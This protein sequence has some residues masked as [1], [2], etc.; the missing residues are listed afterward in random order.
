[1][2][3]SL[4][5]KKQIGGMLFYDKGCGTPKC[6]QNSLTFEKF[7]IHFACHYATDVVGYFFFSLMG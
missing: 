6:H 7:V 2:S 1:M 3:H 4:C 5:P